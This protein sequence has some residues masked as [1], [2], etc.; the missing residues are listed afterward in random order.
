V[1]DLRRLETVRRDFVANVSHELRTPMT[2][3]HALAVT[4]QDYEDPEIQTRYLDKI[5]REVD[6]LTRITD[7]LLTLSIA[8]TGAL[9]PVRVNFA[10]IVG[11][12]FSQL[13]RK[14]SEKGLRAHIVRP[15]E[16]WLMGDDTQ[17]TQII[18][19]LLDNAINYTS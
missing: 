4:L 18:F 1:T 6:R 11:S 12:V 5:I 17:L 8:E 7:D 16:L 14:A 19:N 2:T 9:Q 15:Q 3:I 10:D 13:E